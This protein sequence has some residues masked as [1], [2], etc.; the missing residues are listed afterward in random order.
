M[1]A[2]A[3]AVPH[4]RDPEVE[5]ARFL[6][7]G[8][9]A[10]A[11]DRQRRQQHPPGAED[12]EQLDADNRVDHEEGVG[13]T[14]KHLRARQRHEQRIPAKFFGHGDPLERTLPP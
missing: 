6:K 11:V 4:P 8:E 10:D 9:H 1:I 5:D 14:G 7:A 2:H 13:D 3:R 12:Q